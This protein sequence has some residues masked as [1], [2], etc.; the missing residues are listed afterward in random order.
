MRFEEQLANRGYIVYTND[1]IS[2]MPFLRQHRDIIEI[3]KKE[4]GRYKKYDIVLYKRNDNYILHRILKVLPDGYIIA[5]D[6]NLYVETDISDDMILG[7]LTRVIRN[8]REI[9][10]NNSILYRCYVHFWCAFSFI[11]RAFIHEAFG[12]RYFFRV[13]KGKIS[14]LLNLS[15]NT[16]Q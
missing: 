6:H 1:G 11:R 13:L 14:A 2:M 3:H 4:I 12:V 5:G 7:V 10:V 16:H 8:G 9:D 15:H